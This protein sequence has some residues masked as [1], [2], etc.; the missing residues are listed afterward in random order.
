VNYIQGITAGL[1][2][3]PTR[4]GDI[5]PRVEK[6]YQLHR[7]V[8]TPRGL[9]HQTESAQDAQEPVHSQHPELVEAAAEAA[10]SDQTSLSAFVRQL[11]VGEL[12]RRNAW[13]RKPAIRNSDTVAAV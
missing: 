4:G 8:I 13:P 6:K 11:V 5:H 9:I 7:A 10:E 1:G 2:I 3:R 12:R